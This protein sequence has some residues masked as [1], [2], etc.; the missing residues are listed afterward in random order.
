MGPPLVV[1]GVG[2]I[3]VVDGAVDGASVDVMEDSLIGLIPLGATV[4]VEESR[5]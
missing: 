5:T 2:P 1:V 4:V 3:V